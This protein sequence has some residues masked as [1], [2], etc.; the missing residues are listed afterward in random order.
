MDI[1]GLS[2]IKTTKIKS[3]KIKVPSTKGILPRKRDMA[4][5][6]SNRRI[7][8]PI[9]AEIKNKVRLRAK[10][11]CET[12]GCKINKYLEFHHKNM[13]NDDNRLCNIALLCP[14]HHKERHNKFKK[15]TKKDLLGNET[16][17]KVVHK[18]T[19]KKIK[20]SRQQKPVCEFS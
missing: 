14:Y 15:I 13:K 4:R 17:S 7:R 3:P 11:T 9:S 2:N 18:S 10:N 8:E 6:V 1:F 16:Y 19:A 5:M 12:K 20:K